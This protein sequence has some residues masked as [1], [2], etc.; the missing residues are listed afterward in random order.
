VEK[1]KPRVEFPLRKPPS[2][3]RCK[4]VNG[5]HCYFV[6]VAG[7]PKGEAALMLRATPGYG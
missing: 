6:R 1:S 7:D 4:R 2:G 5:K 3:R